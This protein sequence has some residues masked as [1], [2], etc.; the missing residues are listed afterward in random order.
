MHTKYTRSC[1]QTA[2][3]RH[4]NNNNRPPFFTPPHRHRPRHH[5]RHPNRLLLLQ[6]LILPRTLLCT[7]LYLPAYLT[8]T[9]FIQKQISKASGSAAAAAPGAAGAASKT[10]PSN[11]PASTNKKPTRN[12][13][14]QHTNIKTHKAQKTPCRHQSSI[15]LA[16][17]QPAC[18]TFSDS[19]HA[20]NATHMHKTADTHE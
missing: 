9:T 4:N 6:G 8:R 11:Q 7:R 5:H 2:A 1:H 3:R 10:Q 14:V 20:R 17:Q 13:R 12:S 18:C 19:W 16:A 15:M